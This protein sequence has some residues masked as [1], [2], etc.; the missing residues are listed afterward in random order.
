MR[1]PAKMKIV[2]LALIVALLPLRGIA[3]L[4]TDSCG[5]AQ[6]N[7]QSAVEAQD[8]Q[9]GAATGGTHCPAAVFLPTAAAALWV[10]RGQE[11]SRA[12]LPASGPP[13]FPDNPDRPPLAPLR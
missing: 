1:K 4:M 3:A 7:V 5:F 10:A 6:E 2:L 8:P 12:L 11:C 9:A 13:F